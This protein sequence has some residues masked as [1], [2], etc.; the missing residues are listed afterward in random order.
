MLNEWLSAL[1]ESLW[2][3]VAVDFQTGIVGVIGFGGVIITL[4]VNSRAENKK[5]L[6]EIAIRRRILIGQI[7]NDLGAV[8]S[9]ICLNLNRIAKAKINP[10]NDQFLGRIRHRIPAGRYSEIG[11]LTDVQIEMV[12]TTLAAVESMTRALDEMAVDENWTIEVSGKERDSYESVLRD[13]HAIIG[14]TLNALSANLSS[15]AH[16][17][18]A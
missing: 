2:Y 6:R 9:E 16:S 5:Y 10:K 4:L 8:D 1:T 18:N 13:N 14:S 11:L 7:M 3:E 15:V 17:A 12:I